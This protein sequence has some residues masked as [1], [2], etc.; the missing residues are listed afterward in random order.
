MQVSPR[1]YNNKREVEEF[2][3]YGTGIILAVGALL[4]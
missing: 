1:L 4:S 2:L 3:V